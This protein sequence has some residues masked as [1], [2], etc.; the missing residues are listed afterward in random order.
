MFLPGVWVSQPSAL[1]GVDPV[2]SK[3]FLSKGFCTVTLIGV[4]ICYSSFFYLGY[5]CG[6]GRNMQYN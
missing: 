1:L 2:W 6:H 4:I 3:K 5:A